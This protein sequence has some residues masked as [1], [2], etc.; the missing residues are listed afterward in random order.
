MPQHNLLLAPRQIWAI[1]TVTTGSLQAHCT[2]FTLPS[3]GLVVVDDLTTITLTQDAIFQPECTA[4][5]LDAKNGGSSVLD[6]Q[7][8]FYASTSPQIYAIAA[9]TVISYMLVVMLF[10]TPRTFFIGGTGGGGGFLGRRGLL[11]GGHGSASIIAV[12][13]RPWLQKVAAL[14]VA[15]SLT[16]ATVDTFKVAED[17][18]DNGY[19]DSLALIQEVVGGLTIRVI[20]VISDTFLWLAQVQT[21]I[22]LFPRHREKVIIKWVGFA[23]IVLDTIFSI[24][25]KFIK[26]SG[27]T[28]PRKYVDAIPALSYLFQLALSLLYAAW[29][30][31]YSLEKRRFAYFHPKMRNIFLVA[32]LSL[33]AVLIPVVF[34]VLDISKPAVAG[35][36]DYVR[37]VGAAA[38]S[39]VV[40]E[41]VER[42]EA[43]EREERKDGILG[44]EIFDGDEMLEI[45]PSS[46]VNWPGVRHHRPHGGHGYGLAHA[47][48]RS[49]TTDLERRIPHSSVPNYTHTAQQKRSATTSDAQSATPNATARSISVDEPTPPAAVA[50]PSDREDTTSSTSTEYAVFRYPTSDST[51]SSPDTRL[52]QPSTETRASQNHGSQTSSIQS[53]A[54]EA[55]P[56]EASREVKTP[57]TAPTP[58]SNN[59]ATRLKNTPNPFKRRRTS[60]PPPEV[61]LATTNAPDRPSSRS[62]PSTSQQTPRKFNPLVRLRMHRDAS[63]SRTEL[64]VVVIPAPARGRVWS[65]TSS[66][67]DEAQAGPGHGLVNAA[68]GGILI[69]QPDHGTGGIEGGEGSLDIEPA[70][71]SQPPAF[72]PQTA[73]SS[74]LATESGPAQD[75]LGGIDFEPLQSSSHAGARD[76]GS[77][78]A[79]HAPSV[80]NTSN[81]VTH[82]HQRPASQ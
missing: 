3:A 16:I 37:W 26:Q 31:Y 67:H 64:P 77:E 71:L 43:L 53:T 14:T 29:V 28:A 41:W 47:S 80:A 18:Y 42:I 78:A 81:D 82:T 60:P 13:G 59:F 74:T 75:G 2:P 20:R 35:W 21:L 44:R 52:Q 54:V 19:Q 79:A 8:P 40:W 73:Y 27:K 46:E 48:G 51:A 11:R 58:A 32:I 1:P 49:G 17:Q 4:L 5:P 72:H 55:H 66:E 62:H 24:L 9:A 45:T 23:L 12:G 10:I 36:G 38:A 6:M 22:R 76:L 15:I 7:D 33:A 68:G 56:S 39:V 50:S 63:A 61:S 57:P 65:P 34:F 69:Y 25:N 70:V 30:I